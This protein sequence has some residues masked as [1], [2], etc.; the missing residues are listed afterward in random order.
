MQQQNNQAILINNK[1]K[2]MNRHHPTEILLDT[3]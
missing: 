1:Y 3:V 2:H